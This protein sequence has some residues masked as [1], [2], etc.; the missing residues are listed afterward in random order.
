[1]RKVRVQCCVVRV[2]LLGPMVAACGFACVVLG[3]K[4]GKGGLDGL[5]WLRFRAVGGLADALLC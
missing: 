5:G 2:Q 3:C 1:M 4:G